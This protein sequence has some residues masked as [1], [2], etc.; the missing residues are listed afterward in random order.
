MVFSAFIAGSGIP[1]F[2]LFGQ[3]IQNVALVNPA[4]AAFTA[5]Q[6]ASS[7]PLTA[8]NAVA[9]AITTA[10]TGAVNGF[11]T[12]LIGILGAPLGTTSGVSATFPFPFLPI[13]PS[14]ILI[15]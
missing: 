2:N 15:L 14:G 3:Q 8:A 4:Q 9:S 1:Q 12:L 11:N 10:L 5:I 7:A 6:A 13:F